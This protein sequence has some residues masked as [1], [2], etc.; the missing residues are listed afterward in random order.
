MGEKQGCGHCA[1]VTGKDKKIV[2]PAGQKK[3]VF[4]VCS[5]CKGI[6]LVDADAED[7]Q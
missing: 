6:Y 2:I 3:H 4:G 1:G 5:N 7:A